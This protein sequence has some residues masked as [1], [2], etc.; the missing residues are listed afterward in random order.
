METVAAIRATVRKIR[1]TRND[2]AQIVTEPGKSGKAYGAALAAVLVAFA[3]RNG[4]AIPSE[5]QVS[6]AAVC[7]YGVG[8]LFAFVVAWL[9]PGTAKSD[10]YL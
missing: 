4:L 1:F 10:E 8:S 9:T 6:I 5:I 3:A 7:S 2:L